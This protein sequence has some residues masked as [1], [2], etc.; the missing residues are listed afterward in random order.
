M[1]TVG[2]GGLKP[3]R[4]RGRGVKVA[5]GV[6]LVRGCP[7]AVVGLC[8]LPRKFLRYFVRNNAYCAL[9]HRNIS[10]FQASSVRLVPKSQRNQQGLAGRS[11]RQ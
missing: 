8:P 1:F 2:G 3:P 9:S 10:N 5:E 7:P 11:L 4:L 6:G